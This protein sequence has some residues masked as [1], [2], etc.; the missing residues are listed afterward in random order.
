M[1]AA[2]ALACLFIALWVS[3]AAR[4]VYLNPEGHGQALIFPYYT[5]QSAAT[6]AF[7][8]YLSIANRSFEGKA[9]RVR[10]R[11]RRNGRESASFNL[12]LGRQEVSTGTM[13]VCP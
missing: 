13:N 9:L 8:T 2:L 1:K 4:A 11:E 6:G 5:V 3:P 7:N 10:V 12:F